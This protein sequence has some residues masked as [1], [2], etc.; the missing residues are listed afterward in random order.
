MRVIADLGPSGFARLPSSPPG[1]AGTKNCQPEDSM[2]FAF[3]QPTV[4]IILTVSVLILTAGVISFAVLL[5]RFRA[6]TRIR[7]SSIIGQINDFRAEVLRL[8]EAVR[9]MKSETQTPSQD[10]TEFPTV[11]RPR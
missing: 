10:S 9:Q 5:L 1:L 4:L 7:H 2:M 11:L 3:D 6:L 8:R